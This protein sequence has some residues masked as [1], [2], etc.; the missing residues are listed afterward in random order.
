MI[1]RDGKRYLVRLR[2]GDRFHSHRGM[3]DHDEII[4]QP[5]GR[6]IRSHLGQ[7]FIILRPSLYDLLMNVK[8]SSQ[9]IYPKEIGQILLRLDAG[10]GKRIIEAGTGSG[11]L[12]IAL[13]H[14]VQP[15]GMVY[16]YEVREDM[17]NLARKNIERAGLSAY[18]QLVQRDIV[19]GFDE[20][21]VDAV[22]LDVRE[23]WD[24][25]GQVCDA[26][27]DGGSF[28]ALV[29]TT[30]Q[31]SWLLSEMERYPLISIEVLEVL[32]RKY[33]PVPAR[34]R[35][36]DIMVGHTGYLI[37]ARKIAPLAMDGENE[38]DGE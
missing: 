3:I 26:L 35:P 11:A 5:L 22:F 4:G 36:Q 30:N 6:Q 37:F 31:I 25:M 19:D 8:R 28:G 2:P 20:S 34:L 7:T 1:A 23:P 17:Q 9:I 32:I 33:K 10:N 12:T 18:V 15:D 24:Y 27:G 14:S 13:A 21:E 38:G 16:S 29:P